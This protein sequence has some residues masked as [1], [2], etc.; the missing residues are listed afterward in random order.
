MPICL[1]AFDK[2]AEPRVSHIYRVPFVWYLHRGN[3]ATQLSPTFSAAIRLV[4]SGRQALPA[5][6]HDR[7]NNLLRLGSD[8]TAFVHLNLDVSRL[9]KIHRYLWLAGRP[10]GARPVHRKK[11][12][13]VKID[14]QKVTALKRP[15]N[16]QQ[17]SKPTPTS[18]RKY[19]RSTPPFDGEV[20]R[21]SN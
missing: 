20:N 11:M 12:I 3:N 17:R 2:M 15:A 1:S 19:R 16:S 9:N 14:S 6:Y 21:G 5:A 18:E 7:H 10:T 13:L 4:A 8:L